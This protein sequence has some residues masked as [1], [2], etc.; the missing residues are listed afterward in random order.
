MAENTK[1]LRFDKRTRMRANLNS[2]KVSFVTLLGIGL[3]VYGLISDWVSLKLGQMVCLFVI[4]CGFGLIGLFI[5]IFGYELWKNIGSLWRYHMYWK[6]KS[7]GER[8]RSMM[9][10]K[11]MCAQL[12][13]Q[14]WKLKRPTL[15]LTIAEAW[16]V[17]WK[18]SG[19][20]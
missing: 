11:D 5:W 9:D 12:N 6:Y 16:Y 8:K 1:P 4:T 18:V 2:L 13:V 3:G 20:D 7:F 14:I 15:W 10:H 19:E 17:T